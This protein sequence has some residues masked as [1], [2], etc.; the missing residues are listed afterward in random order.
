MIC[1]SPE[2]LQYQIA[3]RSMRWL[4]RPPLYPI[5]CL[6]RSRGFSI[7]GSRITRDAVQVF[8]GIFPEID[9]GAI[10]NRLWTRGVPPCDCSV[11][12]EISRYRYRGLA[13]I[14]CSRELMQIR[15]KSDHC[16][17]AITLNDANCNRRRIMN[18]RI[19]RKLFQDR[20]RNPRLRQCED[21]LR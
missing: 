12:R 14:R 11:S 8:A 16:R 19:S 10:A 20:E 18:W 17:I 13:V 3:N 15:Q 2:F 9:H 21:I 6:R 7:S 1:D 4:R 5:T